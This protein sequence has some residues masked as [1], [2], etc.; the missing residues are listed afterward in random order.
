MWKYK[1]I[2]A[3]SHHKTKTPPAGVFLFGFM[4]VLTQY[5]IIQL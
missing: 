2:F 1:V 5:V 3:I 4:M